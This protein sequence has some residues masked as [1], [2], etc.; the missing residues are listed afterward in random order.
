MMVDNT[1]YNYGSKAIIVIGPSC[2]VFT[3]FSFCTIAAQALDTVFVPEVQVETL[4]S[5]ICYASEQQ[6]IIE[7]DVL[8]SS[9][10][11]Q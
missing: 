2:Y 6:T 8:D 11:N 10:S 9:S 5:V 7:D 1:I 3:L 4:D